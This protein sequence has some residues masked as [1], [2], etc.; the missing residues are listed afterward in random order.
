MISE[1]EL[2]DLLDSKTGGYQEAALLAACLVQRGW[3][4]QMPAHYQRL[5]AE[6]VKSGVVSNHKTEV[7]AD[8]KPRIRFIMEDGKPLIAESFGCP[9]EVTVVDKT[10]NTTA[11]YSTHE[12]E[13]HPVPLFFFQPEKFAGEEELSPL[14]IDAL[15][16]S[17]QHDDQ[18]DENYGDDDAE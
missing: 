9:I 4:S 1:V 11:Y 12:G 16:D 13:S 8:M 6:F 3:V 5:V 14:A 10:D 2:I 18:H 15:L 17:N 7:T